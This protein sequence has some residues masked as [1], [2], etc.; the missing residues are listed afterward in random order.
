ME[1]KKKIAVIVVSILILSMILP[2]FS[3]LIYSAL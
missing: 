2:T 1:K 3:M